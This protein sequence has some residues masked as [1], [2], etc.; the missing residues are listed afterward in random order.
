MVKTCDMSCENYMYKTEALKLKERITRL[1]ELVYKY[2]HDALTGLLMRRDFEAKLFEYY[3]SGAPFS[4][5]LVDI[6]GLHT[7]NRERGF[8]EGDKL[9]KK[10]AYEL[11]DQCEGLVYRLGGDEFAIL[12]IG[13]GE[14][15]CVKDNIYMI[16][17]TSTSTESKFTCSQEIFNAADDLMKEKKKKYYEGTDKERRN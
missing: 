12:S 7:I 10:V 16:T 3:S 2:R 15:I 6:N 9:I 1:E 17:A 8:S 4:L 14:N 11:N 13:E 5:T